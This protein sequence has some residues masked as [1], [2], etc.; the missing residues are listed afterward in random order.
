MSSEPCAASIAPSVNTSD[1]EDINLEPTPVQ[2]A[3]PPVPHH[4]LVRER[5]Y[6]LLEDARARAVKAKKYDSHATRQTMIDECQK[7]ASVTPYPEQ[8]DLAECMLL[9]LDVTSIAGTGWGKTLT[10]VLPLFVPESKGKIVVIVS[11]LNALEADQAARF[12]KMGLTAI[13][14]NG[15]THTPEV[16]KDIAKGTYSVI[17]VG[18]KLLTGDKSELR[19]LLSQPRFQ[20]KV[21]GLVID[22]AHCICQWG[23]DF[24]KEYS[25]LAVVRALLSALTSILVTSA[26]MTPLVLSNTWKSVQI[27]PDKSFFL[28]L[29]NDRPNIVWRIEYMT[30]G[31]ADL[32]CL[33]FLAP[34]DA[35]ELTCLPKTMVFF[36]SIAQSQKARR[37]LLE[38]L[39]ARF[40]D[41]IKCYNARLGDLT[42]KFVMKGF[43]KGTIDILL[44]TEAAGMGCDI[45]DIVRVV[46]YMTPDSLGVWIQRAGRAGRSPNLQALAI[47]LVETSVFA[48]RGKRD[49]KEGD[50]VTY[51]KT[52]EPG[53]RQYV[54]APKDRCR[55]DVVVAYFDNPPGRRGTFE[56]VG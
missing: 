47:L 52:L 3:P 46:Q 56:A 18:P 9:G 44:T 31:K 48:E 13:A 17:I 20:K 45:P 21:M 4:I 6:K 7:R 49:R 33:H 11:P 8:L 43:R 5:S 35:D 41:R 27:D 40:R 42:K 37:W 50:P 24:R 32:E 54:D 23:G 15:E 1:G 36:D 19:D 38:R 12:Q 30:A 51:V 16:M 14:L 39:P 10:F 53:L 22:E 28:N 26:T 25:Q 29:G 34:D 2:A 55:G